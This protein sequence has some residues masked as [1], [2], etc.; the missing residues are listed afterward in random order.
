[1][2]FLPRRTVLA[3]MLGFLHPTPQYQDDESNYIRK[4][5]RS[6]N[7]LQQSVDA[8]SLELDGIRNELEDINSRIN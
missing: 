7:N 1:M 6:I 3:Q 5:Q 4:L 8:I 2:M